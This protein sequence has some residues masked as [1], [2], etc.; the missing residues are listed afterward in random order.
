MPQSVVKIGLQLRFRRF[1]VIVS[2]ILRST[3]RRFGDWVEEDPA[4]ESLRHFLDSFSNAVIYLPVDKGKYLDAAMELLSNAGLRSPPGFNARIQ[5]SLTLSFFILHKKRHCGERISVIGHSDAYVGF[6][7]ANSEKNWARIARAA[8]LLSEDI[9]R[10]SARCGNSF[11][12]LNL[13]PPIGGTG[14]SNSEVDAHLILEGESIRVA[15][16]HFTGLGSWVRNEFVM[17]ENGVQYPHRDSPLP[18]PPK[19]VKLRGLRGLLGIT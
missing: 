6:I 10:K 12:V 16:F 14:K 18:P 3:T 11:A 13:E 9:N 5:F 7:Y 1:G 15:E 2:Y 19:T 4:S 17:D 8:S